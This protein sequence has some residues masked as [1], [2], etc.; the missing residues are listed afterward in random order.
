MVYSLSG[1]GTVSLKIVF[2]SGNRHGTDKKMHHKRY[3]VNL[4]FM[5]YMK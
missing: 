5:D 2:R 3:N 1:K 4:S